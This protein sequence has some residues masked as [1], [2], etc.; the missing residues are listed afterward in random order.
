[1]VIRQINYLMWIGNFSDKYGV[2]MHAT[3]YIARQHKNISTITMIE[4]K[5][6]R[7][8]D[9]KHQCRNQQTSS[10][11]FLKSE[12]EAVLRQNTWRTYRS[13][14]LSSVIFLYCYYYY[15][16]WW[17]VGSDRRVADSLKHFLLPF[18][19]SIC[20]AHSQCL[21]IHRRIFSFFLSC[22]VT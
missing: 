17:V 16:Y 13:M 8:S 4:K 20:L 12:T 22:H 7:S 10:R 2:R 1:M 15:Y 11:S 3:A 5:Q 21:Q 19:H 18:P 6:R 9:G 14:L